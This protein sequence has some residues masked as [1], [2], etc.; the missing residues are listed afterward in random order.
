MAAGLT[1]DQFW[2]MTPVETYD[3]IRAFIYRSRIEAWQVANWTR[4][5]RLPDLSVLLER[6]LNNGRPV[7]KSPN[8]LL[9]IARKLNFALGGVDMTKVGEN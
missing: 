4:A 9:A 5:Q 1:A 3:A 6:V 2:S 7:R 8:Q